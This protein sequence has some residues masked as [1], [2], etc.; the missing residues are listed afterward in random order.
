MGSIPGQG[1]K[2]LQTM[3]SRQNNPRKI[4]TKASSTVIFVADKNY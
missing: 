2:T 1:T 3:Q 4:T